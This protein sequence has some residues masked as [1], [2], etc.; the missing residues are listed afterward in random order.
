MHLAGVTRNPADM[1]MGRAAESALGFLS[2]CRYLIHDRD[3]KFSL[4]FRIVLE[5][6]GIELIRTPFQAPNAN[7]YA[8]RFVRSIKSECLDRMIL[9]GE[10]HLRR[11]L[12]QFL[13]HY[14]CERNH[15]G[16]GNE[17][18]QRPSSPNGEGPVECTERLGGLLNFYHRA[19]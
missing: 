9:F 16:L 11:A 15:Q 19:A 8:E 13:A 2:G 17:L 4:R 1:F 14:H 3:T 12:D 7:A 18:I 10:R 5:A 6:A